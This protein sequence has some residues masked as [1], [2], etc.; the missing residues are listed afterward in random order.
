MLKSATTTDLLH[1]PTPGAI[2]LEE[3]LKPLGMSQTT[4]ASACGLPPRRINEI[5]PGK[6]PVTADTDLRLTRY[7]GLRAGYSLELQAD[8][9]LM[10]QPRKIGS[11]LEMITPRAAA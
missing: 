6:R 8:H 5:V 10:E 11:A 2:L 3:F 1:N 9:D 4:L 7:W